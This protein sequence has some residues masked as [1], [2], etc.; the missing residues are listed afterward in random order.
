M[1][2]KYKVGLYIGR[3]QPFHMGHLSIVK[4][5]LKECDTLVIAIGSSQENR[6]KKNP[7][8]FE[9]RKAFI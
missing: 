7:F 8:T 9:E 4:R 2:K 6:T 3:F 1:E 5:A